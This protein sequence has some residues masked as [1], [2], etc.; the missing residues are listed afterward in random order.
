[1]RWADFL[2]QFAD[3][4]L[5]NSSMLEIFPE[6]RNYLH[7]QMSRWVKADKLIQ[8]RRSWYLI[9]EPYRFRE[10]PPAVIANNVVSP[11]YLSLDWA[12]AFHGL[13]PEES[14]NPTSVTTVRAENFQV[15]GRL[16]IYRH[17]QPLYFTGYSKMEVQGQDIVIASPEKALWDKLYLHLRRH[18]FSFDWLEELRLQNLEE[19][20]VDQWEKY[21]SMNPS[22]SLH[23]ASQ[24]ITEFIRENRS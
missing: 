18:P 5:F 7:V 10:I 6:S 20:N 11:S 3:K 23:K 2:H 24:R 12:L 21:T 16:F 14:P 4:P 19:F 13:I 17:M 9:A 1:M 8:I 22:P 15:V